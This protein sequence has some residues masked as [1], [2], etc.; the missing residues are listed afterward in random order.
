VIP[1]SD[2]RE[3][4]SATPTKSCF[5][6]QT[7]KAMQEAQWYRNAG[8]AFLILAGLAAFAAFFAEMRSYFVFS[9]WLGSN[10][11][12]DNETLRSFVEW[13]AGAFPMYFFVFGVLGIVSLFVKD[14]FAR[15][16]RSIFLLVAIPMLLLPILREENIRLLL[17][18]VSVCF[19]FISRW[20][21]KWAENQRPR[22]WKTV[23]IEKKRLGWGPEE[24]A[25]ALTQG[26]ASDG[27][28]L[29]VI[30]PSG[31]HL[32]EMEDIQE[33]VDDLLRRG[34]YGQLNAILPPQYVPLTT[35]LRLT[36]KQRFPRALKPVELLERDGVT[37]EELK[38]LAGTL[39]YVHPEVA[40]RA[41]SLI[42]D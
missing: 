17:I 23:L 32:P 8:E 2:F 37:P 26:R 40:G 18:G 6:L 39:L 22:D 21:A 9:D 41:E 15:I 5:N 7:A 10:E 31:G 25:I 3:N 36:S 24:F 27:H 35:M 42:G 19:Y 28:C 1:A 33:K 30:V 38:V 11:W 29:A 20:L 14:T 13:L 16:C 12:T 4:D 34:A